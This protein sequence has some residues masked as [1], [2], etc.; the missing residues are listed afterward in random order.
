MDGFVLKLSPDGS[1]IDFAGVMGGDGFDAAL[2]IALDKSN[3]MYVTGFTNSSNFTSTPNGYQP[4]LSGGTNC[5]L[6]AMNGEPAFPRDC[7]DGFVVAISS[8]G[9]KALYATYFG[10]ADADDA[11][12]DIAVDSNS[13]AYVVGASGSGDFTSTPSAFPVAGGSG[14]LDAF[15]AELNTTGTQL[16]YF[17]L[18]G[19]ST[20]DAGASVALDSTDSDVVIAGATTSTDLPVFPIT[21]PTA[22][23]TEYAGSTRSIH[24]ILFRSGGQRTGAA[25]LRQWIRRQV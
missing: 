12:T 18:F 19:G 1:T 21:A 13:N 17:T 7:F 22:Y 14:Q 5:G 23:Q 6:A 24:A 4:T 20:N 8:D 9:S 16:L 10:G 25:E 2:A 3:N 15:L 11:G